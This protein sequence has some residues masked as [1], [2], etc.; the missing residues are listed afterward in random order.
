MLRVVLD[1]NVF[2]SAVIAKGKPRELLRKQVRAVAGYRVHSA[3]AWISST[4]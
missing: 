3:S 4:G 2:V 1:T